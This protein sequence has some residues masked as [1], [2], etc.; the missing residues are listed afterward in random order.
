MDFRRVVDWWELN[1]DQA[2]RVQPQKQMRDRL[3][4]T[5]VGV[6]L[7]LLISVAV[8]VVVAERS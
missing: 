1:T 2:A 4:P 3:T 6:I 8:V 5:A 7:S